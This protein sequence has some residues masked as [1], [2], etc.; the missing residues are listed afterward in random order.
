MDSL[1]CEGE[2]PNAVLQ[3]SPSG[4]P[5][6]NFQ[7]NL[8]IFKRSPQAFREGLWNHRLKFEFFVLMNHL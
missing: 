1:G 5:L 8:I 6:E 4:P 2:G 3:W 7:V